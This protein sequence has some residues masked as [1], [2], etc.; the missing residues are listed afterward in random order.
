[1]YLIFPDDLYYCANCAERQGID[2]DANG[3]PVPRVIKED[4]Y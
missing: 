2:K 4:T 3:D 1:M